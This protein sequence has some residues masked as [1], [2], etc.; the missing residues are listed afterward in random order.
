M[1]EL[2]RRTSRKSYADVAEGLDDL[3]EDEGVGKRTKRVRE[4]DEDDALLEGESEEFEP[5]S[6]LLQV[7]SEPGQVV[8]RGSDTMDDMEEIPL[9]GKKKSIGKQT[10]NKSKATTTTVRPRAIEDT[11]KSYNPTIKSER[12]T[13]DQPFSH[14]P[15]E[16]LYILGRSAEKI[17]KSHDWEARET[18]RQNLEKQRSKEREMRKDELPLDSI[19]PFSTRLCSDPKNGSIKPKVQWLKEPPT[20]EFKSKKDRKR[21][22][23]W[24]IGQSFSGVPKELWRGEGWWPEMYVGEEG[25]KEVSER[26][27]WLLREEVR[28]EFD[29]VGRPKPSDLVI[30]ANEQARSYLPT[31]ASSQQP[32]INV[33]LGPYDEQIATQF[34]IFDSRSLHETNAE[35]IRQGYTFFAGGPIWGLEWCPI[36]SSKSAELNNT[37]YLAVSTLRNIQ[38]QPEMFERVSRDTKGSIQIWSITPPTLN[39]DEGPGQ[40]GEDVQM[41]EGKKEC[42][43][44]CE[45]VLCVQG[46]C[47]MQ[48]KWMPLGTYDDY[49]ILT[50]GQDIAIPK[51][52]I[53]AA[54]GLDGSIS[55]YSVPHPKFLQASNNTHEPI[56]LK[57]HEPLF[58]ITVPDSA[59]MCFDWIT[60]THIAV[61]LD[62]GHVAT[63]NIREALISGSSSSLLPSSY[64]SLA[65]SCIRSLSVCRIPSDSSSFSKPPIFVIASSYD[66]TVCALDLRDLSKAELQ[67][68]RVPCMATAFSH[69]LPSPLIGDMDYNILT[70]RL[71]STRKTKGIVLGGQRGQIWDISA[72]DYHPMIVSAA[73]DGTVIILNQLEGFKKF[74]RARTWT[75]EKLYEIDYSPKTR[76]YRLVDNFLPQ[77]VPIEHVLNKG[78]NATNKT[79]TWHPETGIHCAKWHN[80]GGIG[81]AGWVASGGA[82]GL[83]RVEWVEGKWKGGEAPENIKME[84]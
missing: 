1:V 56:Y 51:L 7:K 73:A 66:G 41:S 82:S 18:Q 6:P 34:S 78:P 14:I 47:A 57:T 19:L 54:I 53:L 74:N 64:S 29:R 50:I 3:S 68:E 2:R 69:W 25:S 59:C 79:A 45:I 36:A 55:F 71:T 40:D 35:S 58:Q 24:V 31:S 21:F 23:E 84:Q 17:I 65:E 77:T 72:S 80:V 37:Q 48:V 5:D 61:G 10:K 16:Y 39:E 75:S 49:D 67:R 9:K 22:R 38:T 8:G 33:L 15:T 4:D 42:G 81:Q 13:K 27:S 32:S 26:K 46:G 60:G 63:W 12:V 83:G 44:R 11:S 43:M 20:G 52:G 76:T 28:L 30:L 62:N 70:I